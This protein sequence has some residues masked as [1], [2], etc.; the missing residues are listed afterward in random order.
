MIQVIYITLNG[1]FCYPLST[2]KSNDFK[3]SF[4]LGIID[5]YLTCAF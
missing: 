1:T 5:R 2:P 3:G 4:M